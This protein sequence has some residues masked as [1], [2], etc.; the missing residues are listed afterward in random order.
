[1]GN[2]RAARRRDVQLCRRFFELCKWQWNLPN[3]F[4][5]KTW[6]NYTTFNWDLVQKLLGGQK[7]LEKRSG[8]GKNSHRLR[9]RLLQF[10]RVDWDKSDSEIR[11][12]TREKLKVVTNDLLLGGIVEFC[13]LKGAESLWSELKSLEVQWS[14]EKASSESSPQLKFEV[15]RGFCRISKSNH[16][17]NSTDTRHFQFHPP[18]PKQSEIE[19]SRGW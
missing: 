6:F 11:R 14:K 17:M 12:R 9:K 8:A 16:S 10:S 15:H 19:T 1:M 5:T 4:D 2:C 13:H 3:S 7:E 18:D